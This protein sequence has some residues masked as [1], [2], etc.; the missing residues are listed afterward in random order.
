MKKSKRNFTTIAVSIPVKRKLNRLKDHGETFGDLIERLLR[1][2]RGQVGTLF[3]IIIAIFVV[4]ILYLV[5]GTAVDEFIGIT[6]GIAI[7]PSEY[8]YNTLSFLQTILAIAP[9]IFAFVIAVYGIKNA[10]ERR[11]REV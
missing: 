8:R 1:D 4:G 11:S 7:A 2:K 6:N 3:V 5:L 9:I 10:A